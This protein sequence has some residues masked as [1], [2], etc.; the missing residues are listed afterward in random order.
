MKTL[1]PQMVLPLVATSFIGLNT[2][3]QADNFE[4]A[5]Q[6]Q[7]LKQTV[8]TQEGG[9]RLRDVDGELMYEYKGKV[10]HV[11]N[12]KTVRHPFSKTDA[13]GQGLRHIDNEKLQFVLNH[14]FGQY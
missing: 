7:H 12:K 14:H 6:M 3:A 8:Y 10:K 13:K 2:T 1:S 4:L 9:M 5:H 11:L